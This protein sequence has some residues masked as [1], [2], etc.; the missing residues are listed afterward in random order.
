[1]SI[2]LLAAAE[3][4]VAKARVALFAAGLSEQDSRVAYAQ[5]MEHAATRVRS[6]QARQKVARKELGTARQILEERTQQEDTT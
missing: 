5:S 6:A 4:R 2:K 3:A 1:M